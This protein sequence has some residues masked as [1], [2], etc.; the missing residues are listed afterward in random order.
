MV[1]PLSSALHV[2]LVPGAIIG[3]KY[4]IDGI[5]GEGG[6]GVVLSAMHLELDLP[7]AIKVV[8][9]ELAEDEQAVASLIFEARAAAR[10]R[11]SHIVRVLDVARLDT[12]A[13][14]I[15]MERL[16]G[17]DLAA[18]LDEHGVMTTNA[19]VSAVL[20]AC[21]GLAEAHA[22]GIVHR[23][24][25]PANLFLAKTPE[26]T[27][28]KVLDFGI[29]KNLG[30]AVRSGR[31]STLTKA[32]LTVGSPYYMSPEQMR[33]L[34]SLDAR[35]DVWSLGAILFELLTGRCPFE[36]EKPAVI[37]AKVLTEPAPSLRAYCDA[38]AE[39]D[40]I[41]QRCLEKDLGAR[42]QTVSQLADALRA[43][44]IVQPS[45]SVDARRASGIDLKLGSN[46]RS[47]SRNKGWAALTLVSVLLLGLGAAFWQLRT[48]PEAMHWLGLEPV[49]AVQA[50]NPP[51]AAPQQPA[52]IETSSIEVTPGE[53]AP[54]VAI[55][56]APAPRSW[57]RPATEAATPM[58]N[59]VPPASEP[60][61][62][63]P[64]AASP[65]EPTTPLRADRDSVGQRY[66]L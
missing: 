38:P 1:A 58:P 34:P 55:L 15:V 16:E 44:V 5:L 65:A 21:E 49:A 29:S 39:L 8:R 56:P 9:D 3:N 26:G 61:A 33:A 17:S 14:Y 51:K 27:V 42:F 7:V 37:C 62:P 31:R 28:L 4:R 48:H 30:A 24:L 64:R 46:T 20:Q 13:P 60:P 41:I 23:D 40:A 43:L 52:R 11:G 36:G 59:V 53:H 45:A 35:A 2:G 19:A 54:R 25:K 22:L 57:P 12:G 6:M 18:T 50:P 47:A 10:M 66:D 63:A 32:G